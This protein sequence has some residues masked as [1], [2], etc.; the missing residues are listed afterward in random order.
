MGTGT[1]N[2][3]RRYIDSLKKKHRV[4]DEVIINLPGSTTDA[5]VKLLKQKKLHLKEQ[6]TQEENKLKEVI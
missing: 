1:I 5:E 6:I 2:S 3:N 4:L